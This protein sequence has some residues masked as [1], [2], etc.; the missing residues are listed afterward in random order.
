MK[1]FEN[2]YNTVEKTVPALRDPRPAKGAGGTQ[3]DGEDN[4]SW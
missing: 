4:D 2:R 3:K 1:G